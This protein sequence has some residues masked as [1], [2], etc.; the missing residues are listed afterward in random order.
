[1]DAVTA[2]LATKSDKIR[3]LHGRGLTRREIAD[4]LGIQ[5]QHVGNI[6]RDYPSGRK[7]VADTRP[8]TAAE[9]TA[10]SVPSGGLSVQAA[11]L[12]LAAFFGLPPSAIEIVIRG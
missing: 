3:A 9:L 11:K 4:Y 10:V 7:R 8:P 12:G 2:T 1:M 6:I 5:P